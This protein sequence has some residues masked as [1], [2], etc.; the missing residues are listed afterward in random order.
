[1]GLYFYTERPGSLGVEKGQ[2][3]KWWR[4]QYQDTRSI[5]NM[6]KI[7]YQSK[8]LS[9]IINKPIKKNLETYNPSYI[10]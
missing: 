1:M 10:N 3:A 4:F 6:K 7:I 2:G 9:L 8:N 5:F